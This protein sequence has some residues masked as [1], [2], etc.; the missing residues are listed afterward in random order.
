MTPA[1]FA[2]YVRYKTRTNSTTFPDAEILSYMAIRQDE[3]AKAILKADEDILLIPQYADLLDGF[4]EYPFPSDM[5]AR[6]KRVEAKLDGTNWIPLTEI[7]ITQIN[8]P[9]VTEANITSVFNS[10]QISKSNPNGARFDIKRKALTIYSGTIIDVLEGLR[11]WVMTYPTAI[12]DLSST[13][14]M[15]I[16]PSTTTHGVPRA[17]HEIWAR[18]VIIDYKESREKPIILNETELA[19][20]TDEQKA[21]ET[22][23]HGNLDREVIANLP[24][25]SNRGNEGSDY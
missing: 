10:S 14:D 17:M 9:I 13:T 23:R 8:D 5:L 19:Y 20:E 12:T 15:S 2:T 6:K 3:V 1:E 7:D 4:R 25:A 16:D 24:P 21:I 11:V 18:G 22:L